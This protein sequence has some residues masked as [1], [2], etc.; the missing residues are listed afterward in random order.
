MDWLKAVDVTKAAANCHTD[1]IGD[2]YRDP[3]GWPELAWVAAHG[4]VEFLLPALNDSGVR[5]AARLD[6]AKENFG[7]RPATVLDP[8]DRLV[9][10]ALVDRISA[11]L[12]GPMAAWVYGWRLRDDKPSAGI[13]ARN[14]LEWSRYRDHF[15]R[16]VLWDSSALKTD[17]VSY[18][19]SVPI[20]RI[21]E[22]IL[23]RAGDNKPTQRLCDML[24]A[25]DSMVGRSGLPQ[26]SFASAVLAHAYLQ[27]IDDALEHYN[28]MRGM[29]AELVPEGRA[30]RWMD[31][32][33]LFG[34]NPDRLRQAQLD[35]QEAMRD[36]GLEMNSGKTDVL[37]GEELG[38]ALQSL[39]RS[40]VDDA[41]AG[42]P[43]SEQPLNELLDEVLA[44]P[45]HAD[46]T[47]IAFATTRMRTHKIFDRVDE[48]A[49]QSHRM[50]HG[51][52]HLARLFRDSEA[53]RDLGEWYVSYATSRWGTVEWAVA[54]LGTMFPSHE[55]PEPA[56]KTFFTSTVE[57]R[58]PSLA[59]FSLAIQRLAA[60]DAD[61]ARFALKDAATKLDHPLFR[62][63]L[64]L[65][66]IAAGSTRAEI[67]SLLSEF[68]ENRLT[69]R[70]LE[71]ANFRKTSVKPKADFDGR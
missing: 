28:G 56:V 66:G 29:G 14:D 34:P 50:P 46:R 8:L 47:T 51:A 71:D 1:M 7:I 48:V 13:Y 11:K 43:R 65:A 69:L 15:K 40:A 57:R 23:E 55:S 68:E 30:L 20:E 12:I 22:E 21:S 32:V 19:S 62:R 35:L 42:S 39:E 6:V 17:I 63:S 64:A 3:W 37:E 5:H 70:M 10:Q 26:R 16:L 59:L 18:F 44:N 53:Y 36:L 9:Y 67:R 4:Q 31:D 49:E 33:W 58:P 2:W 27:T 38:E 52:D 24:A 61:E 60:W 25:W 54:Q 41:L 45:E